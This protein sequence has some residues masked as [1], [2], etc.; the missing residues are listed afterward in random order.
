MFQ[1]K[2]KI[3]NL[4]RRGNNNNEQNINDYDLNI[5]KSVDFRLTQMKMRFTK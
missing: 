2:K 1:Y 3:L 5:I 4:F